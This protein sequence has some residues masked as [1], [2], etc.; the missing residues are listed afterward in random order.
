MT[1]EK[2][3]TPQRKETKKTKE[4]NGFAL[5][6]AFAIILA[7]FAIPLTFG[8]VMSK[9]AALSIAAAA[10]F[11]LAVL[12]F[13]A[14]FVGKKKKGANTLSIVLGAIGIPIYLLGIL[15]IVGGVRGNRALGYGKKK[16]TKQ[17]AEV[18]NAV[19]E[20]ETGAYEGKS[21]LSG[22]PL[23]YVNKPSVSR[24]LDANN[25]DNI[26]V[27]NCEGLTLELEQLY[28]TAYG[29]VPYF[30]ARVTGAN[31]E[32]GENV[33]FRINYEADNYTVETDDGI[34]TAVHNEYLNALQ[35]S[36]NAAAEKDQ[37][38]EYIKPKMGLK[39]KKV[40]MIIISVSYALLF[41][42]GIS[43]ASVPSFGNI[44]SNIGICKQAAARAY[45]ITIGVMMVAL[46]PA[47]GLYYATL[48]PVNQSGKLK[49][50]LI[51]SS[52]ALLLV[53][54]AI[55]FI[56]AYCAK[57]PEIGGETGSMEVKDFYEGSDVWFIPVSM[58][59]AS[60]GLI[61]CHVLTLFRI[62][63][64][65]INGKKPEK[66][67]DSLGAVVK[68]VVQSMLYFLICV[69]K[70]VLGCKEKQPDLFILI[71]TVLL[72]WLAYFVSFIFSIFCIVLFVSIIVMYFTGLMEYLYTPGSGGRTVTIQ[73]GMHDETLT[74]Q[75][76]SLDGHTVWKNESGKE[77]ISYDNN[78]TFVE[79]HR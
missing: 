50:I 67:G 21:L 8:A 52:I 45:G 42:F 33:V 60:L 19:L 2:V 69:I 73:V 23:D 71:S 16:K 20:N 49:K 58:V 1:K 35:V 66:C 72:T 31:K 18:D 70:F 64:A 12:Q 78:D 29:G 14:A 13:V 30:V 9:A 25:R 7:A 6:L 55:F 77:Y 11:V 41:L 5:R 57:L 24:V 22:Y 75:P 27:K 51:F 56:V 17:V 37:P 47:V 54:N 44:I 36:Q 68:Y 10:F 74:E 46:T 39:G 48:A 28:V 79:Y 26:I 59:F 63:P 40:I 76:Y 38:P 61:I 4:K 15:G 62:N 43:L 53:T 32:D 34:A 3:K 65:K